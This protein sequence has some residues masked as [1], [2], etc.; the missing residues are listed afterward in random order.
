MEPGCSLGRA[1]SRRGL[2]DSHP[3]PQGRLGSG[4]QAP[5]ADL[6]SL[7]LDGRARICSRTDPG[8]GRSLELG[9]SSSHDGAS[10]TRLGCGGVLLTR[11]RLRDP[12]GGVGGVHLT[13]RRLRDRL[14]G[15]GDPAAEGAS[16][17]HKH[18]E[19]QYSYF[20][21]LVFLNI[22]QIFF[23]LCTFHVFISLFLFFLF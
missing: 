20:L 23:Q 12:A 8:R 22:L 1:E 19:S 2:G 18:K 13:R 7:L 3:N 5:L 9:A 10:G 15:G 17:T 11:R 14:G 4:E 21:A 6:R 16:N